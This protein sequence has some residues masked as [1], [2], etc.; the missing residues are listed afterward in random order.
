MRVVVGTSSY[1]ICQVDRV[2]QLSQSVSFA[3][4]QGKEKT[5]YELVCT[6][7]CRKRSINFNQVS[8]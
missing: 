7:G 1:C 5:R 3:G 4:S 8:N 6:I 2:K